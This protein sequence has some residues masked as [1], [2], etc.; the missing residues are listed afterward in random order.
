MLNNKAGP[1]EIFYFI[2]RRIKKR[3]LFWLL[4]GLL[5]VLCTA[6]HFYY[7]GRIYPG[8]YVKDVHLGN[9]TMPEAEKILK[10]LQMTFRGPGRN[11]ALLLKKMGVGL[12]REEIISG[13]LQKGRERLWPLNYFERLRLKKG[14]HVPL[15]YQIDNGQLQKCIESLKKIFEREPE[16]ACYEAGYSTLTPEQ[17]GYHLQEEQL[18]SGIVKTLQQKDMPLIITV[19]VD[20]LPP[21]LTLAQLAEKGVTTKIA[22]FKTIFDASNE[23]RAHNIALAASKLEQ[24]LLAPGQI[25]SFNRVVGDTTPEKGYREALVIQDGKYV[26]GYG[27]GVCQVSSTLY[28]TALLAGLKILERHHHRFESDYVPAGR[29]ATVAYGGYDLQFINNREHYILISTRVE[30]GEIEIAMAGSPLQEKV[31]IITRQTSFVEPYLLIE[32]TSALPPGEVETTEGKPGGRVEVWRMVFY[33]GGEKTEELL[34]VDS[35]QPY[36]AVLRR[37]KTGGG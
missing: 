25:F 14:V 7:T 33:A 31:E 6:D 37:G 1:E 36:P 20:E 32:E 30:K 21:D 28:N 13:C 10:D 9:K 8:V 17:Y 18:V 27:G 35:Y 29:D 4:L 34:F 26:T 22:S 24:L 11:E 16:N 15:S 5:F 12:C 23:N 19:P 2:C 3:K